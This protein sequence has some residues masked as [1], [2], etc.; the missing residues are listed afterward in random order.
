MKYKRWRV[1]VIP[2]GWETQR[3][4][5][6]TARVENEKRK[7]RVAVAG[8]LIIKALLLELKRLH[9]PLLATLELEENKNEKKTE[10]QRVLAEA[11]ASPGLKRRM[12]PMK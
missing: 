10:G 11:Q 2:K 8:L 7:R 5:T 4:T 9:L 3:I 6:L 12:I 1:P